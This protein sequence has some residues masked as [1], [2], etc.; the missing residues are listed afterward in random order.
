M[1]RNKILINSALLL[2]ATFGFTGCVGDVLDIDPHTM[3]SA[4]ELLSSEE[5]IRANMANLYGRLPIEDFG[6]NP[7]GYNRGGT[8][9]NGFHLDQ[10][11]DN[12][13]NSQTW[14]FPQGSAYTS[15][16]SYWGDGWKL[17]RDINYLIHVTPGVTSLTEE[18]KAEVIAEAQYL[19]AFNYFEMA[20]RYGGIP[21]ITEYQEYIAGEDSVVFKVKRATE[22]DTYNFIL[23]Q[24]D[25]AALFLPE[26]RS[27]SDIRR[28]SKY[29]AL[30]FKSRVALF[31]ASVAKYNTKI[32]VSGNAANLGYVGMHGDSLVNAYYHQCEDAA[33]AVIDSGAYGLYKPNPS[34]PEEATNN[35]LAYFQ[36]PN[37]GTQESIIVKGYKEEATG[38]GHSIDFWYGPSQTADGSPHP[39]RMNPSTSLIEA[40]ETYDAPGS[41]V[42]IQT[43][44][45]HNVKEVAGF[46]AKRSYIH[47]AKI[48]D[49]FANKDA[50]MWATI[51]IPYTEWKGQT[52]RIQ[53]GYIQ[54]NGTAVQNGA[55]KSYTLNGKTYWTYGDEDWNN[56]SGFQVAQGGRMTRTGFSF[57]KFLN[58]GTAENNATF[59]NSKQDWA[60]LRYAEVLLNYAEAVCEN[61]STDAEKFA[62][63]TDCLNAT[64][65]RAGHTVAIELN[66]DNVARERRVEFAFEN[67]RWWDL[68]RRRELHEVMDHYYTIALSPLLDLRE[69]TPSY[70]LL[71]QRV[72]SV[73]TLTFDSKNYYMQIPNTT[74]NGLVQ[75]PHM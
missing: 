49:A 19:R 58:P 42:P 40:Y 39:G 9:D 27:G 2:F 5:G 70:I 22:E 26:T 68:L 11:T 64:R 12:A 13:C 30:A 7:S 67:K 32:D 47:F 59:G 44:N 55:N 51:I 75:N 46:D 21:L 56:Y 48:S 71:R 41:S 52:I 20:K 3:V 45:D 37:V 34:S 25:S 24:L 66:P 28:I 18:S 53:S 16:L 4:E 17:N 61:D 29:G 63:A 33:K 72:Q 10:M 35:L 74:I 54:P 14:K 57:K 60:E 69:E 8:N 23:S 43:R 62:L 1:K 38:A 65:F 50:R 31:A 6:F 15:Y 73:A 36:N